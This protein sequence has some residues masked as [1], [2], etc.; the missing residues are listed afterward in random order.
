MKIKKEHLCT[1]ATIIYH[2]IFLSGA[3]FY[4]TEFQKTRDTVIQQVDRVEAQADKLKASGDSIRTSIVGLST[5][6][7]AVG[8]KLDDVKRTC[9]KLRF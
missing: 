7:D 2:C 9:E 4:V 1:A 3:G 5:K 6:I 8:N